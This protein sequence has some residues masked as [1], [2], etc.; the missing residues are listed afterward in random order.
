[1]YAG[2]NRPTKRALDG[3]DS[4]AFSGFIYTQAESCSQS[5]IHIRPPASNAGRWAT[6][7]SKPNKLG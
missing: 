4:A 2:E 3:W 5:F 1:V 7:A 6:L